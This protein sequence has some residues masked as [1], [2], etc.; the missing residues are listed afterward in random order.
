MSIAD[1]NFN[2]NKL[3]DKISFFNTE[4]R[5][6]H[7]AP[8]FDGAYSYIYPQRSS[9][10]E[11][12]QNQEPVCPIKEVSNQSPETEKAS[13]ITTK[14]TD[15]I[16]NNTISKLSSKPS[17][18]E[19]EIYWA[20]VWGSL[21]M[22][23]GIILLA[24]TITSISLL[25]TWP[26]VT[27]Y[28]LWAIATGFA[29]YFSPWAICWAIGELHWAIDEL[30]KSQID[31][32]QLYPENRHTEKQHTE[33]R[34]PIEKSKP[35]EKKLLKDPGSQK[36]TTPSSSSRL[37]PSTGDARLDAFYDTFNR[38]KYF[39]VMGDNPLDTSYLKNNIHVFGDTSEIL[40][41]PYKYPIMQ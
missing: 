29:G 13:L 15:S 22:V 8:H 32:T 20:R 16:A 26:F 36:S 28:I 19:N 10:Q 35:S 37:F 30:H 5:T 18:N 11:A 12:R 23:G 38:R 24:F 17:S 6:E 41:D 39:P 25:C 40:N 21:S 34:R 3:K 31:S 2:N 7:L 33:Y 14:K 27:S 9:V 4:A 1:F